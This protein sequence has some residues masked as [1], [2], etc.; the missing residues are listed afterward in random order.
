MRSRNEAH[1]HSDENLIAYANASC[2]VKANIVVNERFTTDRDIATGK[3]T[4]RRDLAVTYFHAKQPQRTRP[5]GPRQQWRTH[6][7]IE[8]KVSANVL[9]ERREPSPVTDAIHPSRPSAPVPPK[10]MQRS[11]RPIKLADGLDAP[12]EPATSLALA[13]PRSL[14]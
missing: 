14:A 12:A 11:K 8:D 2:S 9:K 1:T 6:E 5:H 7:D 3:P 13:T 10:G 4:T